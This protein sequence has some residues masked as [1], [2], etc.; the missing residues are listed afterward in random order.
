M[1]L[2]LDSHVVLWW[3][4]GSLGPVAD[5]ALASADTTAVSVVTPWELGLKQA[6]GKLTIPPV[7]RQ[8]LV[9]DG[10]EFL[11]ITESHVD[12]AVSLPLHHRDPFDR[13]LIAQAKAE[14]LTLVTADREFARYDVALLDPR[15]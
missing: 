12:I 5:E 13:M 1:R 8:L 4:N 2:L 9:A 14:Q 6:L 7:W 15:I 3:L 11:P 10:F